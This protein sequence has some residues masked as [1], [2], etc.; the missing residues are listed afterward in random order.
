[1]NFQENT[2]FSTKKQIKEIKNQKVLCKYSTWNDHEGGEQGLQIPGQS[3]FKMHALAIDLEVTGHFR[4]NGDR[5]LQ[6]G[7]CLRQAHVDQGHLRTGEQQLQLA[8]GIRQRR[9]GDVAVGETGLHKCGCLLGV[10]ALHDLVGLHGEPGDTSD[11]AIFDLIDVAEGSAALHVEV[12]LLLQ[13][14]A[15]VDLV[16]EGNQERGDV[17]SLG[18]GR[19]AVHGVVDDAAQV[20]ERVDQHGIV[21]GRLVLQRLNDV[22]Q[23]KK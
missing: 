2:F 11:E 15:E 19:Q 10:L 16:D 9:D 23:S 3:V 1:M 8:E 21:G 6:E 12:Q 17:R 7:V 5:G 13:V 20:E 4:Q 22:L 18:D 14:L